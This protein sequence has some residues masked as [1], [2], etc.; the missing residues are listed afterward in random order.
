MESQRILITNLVIISNILLLI[1]PYL[2][3]TAEANPLA[4]LKVL[5]LAALCCSAVYTLVFYLLATLRKAIAGE[6]AGEAGSAGLA[7]AGKE[8][9][10]A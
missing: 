1:I 2:L 6:F 4:A 5:S 8:I 10:L 9:T 7:S 3:L